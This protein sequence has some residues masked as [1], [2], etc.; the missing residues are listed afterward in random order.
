MA[1]T[2]PSPTFPMYPGDAALVTASDTATFA[3]SVIYVG[4]AGNVR[5]TTAQGTD[6]VFTG[7]NAGTVLPVQ[8]IKVWATNTTATALARIF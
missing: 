8:A 3:P 7:L 4:G 1:K 6:I 5:I 2:N